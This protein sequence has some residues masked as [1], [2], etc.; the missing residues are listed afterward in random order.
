MIN[1]VDITRE[2]SSENEQSVH[3]HTDCLQIKLMVMD[4][5]KFKG[6]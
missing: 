3:I 6:E 1:E 2:I 5:K 4:R